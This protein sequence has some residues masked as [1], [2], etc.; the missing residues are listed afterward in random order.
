MSRIVTKKGFNVASSQIDSEWFADRIETVQTPSSSQPSFGGQFTLDYK[1]KGTEVFSADLVFNLSQLT[2]TGSLRLVPSYFF[3]DHI[4]LIQ[5]GAIVETIYPWVDFLNQQAYTEDPDRISMNI[6][7]GIYSSTAQRTTLASANNSYVLPLKFYF[8]Y[9]ASLPVI[10]DG[11]CFQLRVYM[12]P[13]SSLTPATN[14]VCTIQSVNLLTKVVYLRDKEVEHRKMEVYKRPL[15]LKYPERKT[16][17]ATVQS[18]VSSASVVL[19]GLNGRFSHLMFVVRPVTGLTGENQYAFTQLA[20]YAI[21]NSG[22]TNIVGGVPITHSLQAYYNKNWTLSSYCSENALGLNNNNANV[23]IYSFA[24]DPIDVMVS[25][26]SSGFYQFSGSEQ[27]VLNFASVLGANVQVD[28]CGFNE[29]VI[30][31]SKN[32][33]K[34]LNFSL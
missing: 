10:D 2:G 29:S 24:S 13:L 20:S 32:H 28:I 5:D 6:A 15:H 7:T 26:K 27:L 25:G 16:M 3:P 23:Y 21:M 18:G 33:I 14:P 9:G 1:T 31:V 12:N 22:S 8:T 19:T 30:E 11:H 34:K 17:S 4:D